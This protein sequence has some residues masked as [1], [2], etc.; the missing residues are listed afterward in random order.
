MQIVEK[1]GSYV[2]SRIIRKNYGYKF[3]VP[4]SM[5]RVIARASLA[6]FEEM[7]SISTQNSRNWSKQNDLPSVLQVTVRQNHPHRQAAHIL[8]RQPF[9]VMTLEEIVSFRKMAA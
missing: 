1:P 5:T 6:D 7:T 3:D 9:K 2:V 8:I 4:F